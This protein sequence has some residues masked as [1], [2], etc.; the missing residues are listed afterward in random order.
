MSQ[1]LFSIHDAS[2]ILGVAEHKVHYAHRIGTL[3]DAT[4]RVGGVRVYTAA[5]IR[6]MAAYFKVPIPSELAEEGGHHE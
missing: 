3:P 5:D 1:E 4:H 6:R 2:K